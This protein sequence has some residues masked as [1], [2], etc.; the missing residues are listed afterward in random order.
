M[1]TKRRR[2]K[3]EKV[4]SL[5]Q[6]GLVVVLEDLHDPHNAEAILRNCDA[7]GVQDVYFIFDKEQSYDPQALGKSSSSSANKWISVHIFSSAEQCLS[8]LKQEGYTIVATVLDEHASSLYESVL[9]QKKL[10]ILFG[11]EREGLSSLAVSQ[12]DQTISI[13][14]AGMVQSLNVSV[15][16][17]IFLYEVMRQRLGHKQTYRLSPWKKRALAEDFLK[18]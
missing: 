8:Q 15:T 3:I 11:N 14:M 12:S 9:M 10:A 1:T 13:P 5:R 16:A 17:G 6:R 4:V 7:F 2:E 18:R